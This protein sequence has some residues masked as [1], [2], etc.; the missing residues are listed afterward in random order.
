MWKEPIIVL[1][2]VQVF[3][4]KYAMNKNQK[5]TSNNNEKC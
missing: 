1:R 4:D 5:K 3:V 2:R